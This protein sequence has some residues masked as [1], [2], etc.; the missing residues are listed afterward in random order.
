MRA[1]TKSTLLL[2]AVLALGV[3]IGFLISGALQNR[4]L[5]RI[6]EMRTGRGMAHSIERA[7]EPL[8]DEQRD[9][10]REVLE[11]AA[12]RFAEVFERNR[13]ETRAIMDSVM[14]ELS[15]FLT[16]EQGEALRRHLEMRRHAPAGARP[17]GPAGTAWRRDGG[18]PPDSAR[19][20][21]GAPGRDSAAAGGWGVDGDRPPPP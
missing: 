15:T 13:E 3:V 14:E 1:R 4:R 5:S 20:R 18:P 10:V 17:Q 9:R 11:G 19:W 2:L 16:D 7:V 21:E 8:T 12:P 6:A